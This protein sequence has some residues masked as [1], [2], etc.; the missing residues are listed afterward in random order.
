MQHSI[1]NTPEQTSGTISK[2]KLPAIDADAML[3]EIFS[4]DRRFY[5]QLQ[6]VIEVDNFLLWRA[7]RTRQSRR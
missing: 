1:S 5:E 3:K 6:R 7:Q 2:E 4:N